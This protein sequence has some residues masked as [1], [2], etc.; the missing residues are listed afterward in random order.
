MRLTAC[1]SAASPGCGRWLE[2]IGLGDRRLPA[3][4]CCWLRRCDYVKDEWVVDHPGAAR[5][6]MAGGWRRSWWA[7]ALMSLC[8][9]LLRL[10]RRLGAAGGA[11]ARSRSWRPCA[12]ALWLRCS[13]CLPRWA[14]QPGRLLRRSASVCACDRRPDRVRVRHGDVRLS[15]RHHPMPL[16]IVVN[17]MDE[18]MSRADP[19]RGA[20]VHLPR[21]AD[22]DDGTG[23]R[24]WSIS[25]SPARPCARRAV[26]RAAGGDV[27]GLRHLRVQGGGHGGG[28]ARCC[29]PR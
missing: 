22:R 25:S 13:R 28:G 24:R 21:P 11:R 12:G 6:T 19:A 9:Q 14:T 5:C 29:S 20:A 1:S 7:A 10:F 27:P 17:R 15:R 18:G 23:A 26:L 3:A 16:T 2:A 8:R 4:W